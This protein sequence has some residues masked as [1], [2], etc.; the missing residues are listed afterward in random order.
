MEI[1]EL[2]SGDH[3][4]NVEWPTSLEHFLDDARKLGHEVARVHGVDRWLIFNPVTM[5]WCEVGPTVVP[6]S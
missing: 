2:R 1:F 4:R 6:V 5:V 3:H